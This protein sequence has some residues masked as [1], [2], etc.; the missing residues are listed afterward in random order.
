MDIDAYQKSFT[1]FHEATE[2]D[3]NTIPHSN[4]INRCDSGFGQFQL[5]VFFI[6]SIK[7]LLKDSKVKIEARPQTKEASLRYKLLSAQ[8]E[9]QDLLLSELSHP[10]LFP[11]PTE[12]QRVQLLDE[13]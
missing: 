13:S 5:F 1:W 4:N 11:V 9:V 8:G 12:V 10:D 7:V 6:S 3:T 2:I